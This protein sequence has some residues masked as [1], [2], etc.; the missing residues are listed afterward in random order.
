[1]GVRATDDLTLVVDLEKPS[2]HFLHLLDCA[3]TFPVPLHVVDDLGDAW[4][5]PENLVTNGPFQLRAWRPGHSMALVRNA[6]YHGRFAGNAEEVIALFPENLHAALRC[7]EAD[8]ADL[9]ALFAGGPPEE[10]YR[11]RERYAGEYLSM[12]EA[13]VGSVRF[14]PDRPPFDDIRV[15]RAFAVAADQVTLAGVALFGLQT[16]A[17]GGY[18]PPGMPGHSPGIGLCFDADK[19]RRVLSQAGYPGGRGFPEVVALSPTGSEPIADALAANWRRNLGV[20]IEFGYVEAGAFHQAVEKEMPHVWGHGSSADYLDPAFFLTETEGVSDAWRNETY[21]QLVREARR[22]T[23]QTRRMAL[24]RQAD[25]ILVED[26]VEVPL[27]YIRRD[28]VVKP[29]VRNLV[30]GQFEFI[31]RDVIIEAH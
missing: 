24:Y 1:V 17:L 18:V 14:A 13:G 15:R 4:A 8:D 22:S 30:V 20:D 2:G 23:D 11:A 12:P 5:R 6:Y 3:Y 10:V 21:N 9:F 7:Y 28:W 27:I 29:W 31:W 16:P 19:A 25:R 26:A